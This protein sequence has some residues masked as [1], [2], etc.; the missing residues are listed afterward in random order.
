MLP[1][2][3]IE[4]KAELLAAQGIPDAPEGPTSISVPF[5]F[6]P[7]LQE[8]ETDGSGALSVNFEPKQWQVRRT[9]I[10][11][12]GQ[13]TV[14]FSPD[15]AISETLEPDISDPASAENNLDEE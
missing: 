6:L 4:I 7:P 15:A 13:S 5:N 12:G 3:E 8:E 2:R 1:A 14:I 11:G 9:L 10:G